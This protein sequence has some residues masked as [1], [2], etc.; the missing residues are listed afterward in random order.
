M[1]RVA[2]RRLTAWLIDWLAILGWAAVTAAIGVPLYL[3][4]ITGPM[5][6][7]G[8][9]VLATLV[10]VVPVVAGF[11]GLE[12]SRREASLGKRVRRLRV[13]DVETGGGLSFGR[14]L[15]RNALKIG[16]PWMVGHLAVF[17]IS[18]DSAASG[19]VSWPVWT[20]TVLAYVLPIW[21]VVSL[22]TG[23]GRTPYDRAAR[24][25]V[26]PDPVPHASRSR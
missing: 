25:R 2:W 21:Y 17:A 7:I 18:R 14:A 19:S 20:L 4:G 1:H 26:I 24:A 8:L 6:T 12:A 13:V 10:L 15:L 3:A 22:F 16:L 11:A 9:N 5:G 23:D